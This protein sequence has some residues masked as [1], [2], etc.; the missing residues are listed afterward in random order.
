MAQAEMGI[1]RNYVLHSEAD[2]DVDYYY[3][4]TLMH[5]LYQ[6]VSHNPIEYRV[7]PPYHWMKFGLGNGIG[8]MSS[9]IL[10]VRNVT[11]AVVESWRNQM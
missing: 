6:F 11:A 10:V 7:Q 3:Y 2:V 1:V 9:N 5:R 8:W 4:Q